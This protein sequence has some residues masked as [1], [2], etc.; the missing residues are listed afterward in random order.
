MLIMTTNDQRA[1]WPNAKAQLAKWPDTVL[2]RERFEMLRASFDRM[3]GHNA[4]Q[5]LALIDAEI[6]RR[7][8]SK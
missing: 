8:A 2:R 6:T 1:G 3:F 4:K 5:A 7:L